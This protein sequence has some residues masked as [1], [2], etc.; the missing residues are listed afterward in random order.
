MPSA[1]EIA[2]RYFEVLD[3]HDLDAAVACSA[4]GAVDQ[5]RLPSADHE[6]LWF[7]HANPVPEDVVSTLRQ[8]AAARA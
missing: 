5:G 8:V 2:R 4:P 7:G 1:T 6:R 3:A